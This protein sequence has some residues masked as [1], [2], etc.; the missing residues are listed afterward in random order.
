AAVDTPLASPR[1]WLEPIPHGKR[2]DPAFASYTEV[3]LPEQ[4]VITVEDGDDPSHGRLV[5]VTQ[6]ALNE[7]R[8]AE[9]KVKKLKAA[10]KTCTEK[11]HI[12]EQRLKTAFQKQRAQYHKDFARLEQE[13]QEAETL[14][15]QARVVL[16]QVA[17]GL[18]SEGTELTEEPPASALPSADQVF[19][20]WEREDDHGDD[21]ILRRALAISMRTP[22]R[23]VRA[24]PR[25][26]AGGRPAPRPMEVEP[27]NPMSTDPYTGATPMTVPRGMDD[28]PSM[29]VAKTTAAPS[30]GQVPKHPG[31]R[32]LESARVPTAVAPPRPGIKDATKDATKAKAVQQKAITERLESKRQGLRAATPFGLGQMPGEPGLGAGHAEQPPGTTRVDLANLAIEADDDEDG[33]EEIDE[34]LAFRSNDLV[35]AGGTNMDFS[36]PAGFDRPLSSQIPGFFI[37]QVLLWQLGVFRGATKTCRGAPVELVAYQ[38]A[39]A[40]LLGGQPIAQVEHILLAENEVDPTQLVQFLGLSAP[41][42]FRVSFWPRPRENGRLRLHEGDVVTFGYVEIAYEEEDETN[43]SSESSGDSGTDG[44][45]DGAEDRNIPSSA[46]G[47]NR[48]A[49]P[50]PPAP[51]RALLAEDLL[52][53]DLHLAPQITTV[54]CRVFV[55]DFIPERVEVQLDLPATLQEL[56]Q[57]LH[58]GRDPQAVVRFPHLCPVEP[59]T[60]R[61]QALFVALPEWGP[62][63]V[64]A[65][66]NTAVIDSRVFAAYLPPYATAD[67]LLRAA[68]LPFAA[69]FSVFVGDDPEPLPDGVEAH[70][71]PGV[72]ILIRH[73]G[74]EPGPQPKLPTLLGSPLHWTQVEPLP[75]PDIA[76]AYCLAQEHTHCL[77]VTDFDSSPN[78]RRYLAEAIGATEDNCRHFSATPTV[79]DCSV[80][81]VHCCSALAA[82]QTHCADLVDGLSTVLLDKRAVA[83][84]FRMAF[85]AT[86]SRAY[87]VLRSRLQAET[88]LGWEVFL[89]PSGDQV[90]DAPLQ[91]GQ[92]FAVGYRR[93]LG[94]ADNVP[95]GTSTDNQSTAANAPRHP[96]TQAASVEDPS[97]RQSGDLEGR[98]ASAEPH[99]SFGLETATDNADLIFL[100]LAPDYRPESGVITLDF[101][102]TVPLAIASVNAVRSEQRWMWFPVVIPVMPQPDLDYLYLL[103]KPS[104]PAFGVFVAFDTRAIDGRLFCNNVPMLATRQS[105]LA[106]AGQHGKPFLQVFVRDMPWPLPEDQGVDLQEGDLIS[107]CFPDDRVAILSSPSDRLLDRGKAFWQARDAVELKCGPVLSCDTPFLKDHGRESTVDLSLFSISS[108]EIFADLLGPHAHLISNWWDETRT[109]VNHHRRQSL[110]ILAG[111]V[112]S[113]VGS[114]TS[115]G[116]GDHGAETEDDPGTRWRSLIEEVGCLAPC[117]FAAFQWGPTATYQHK[118]GGGT[119][120]PDMIAIPATWASGILQA[121]VAP[122][123][124]VALA[125]PDHLATCVSVK[126]DFMPAGQTKSTRKRHFPAQLFTDPGNREHI[127][128]AFHSIPSVPWGV[129]AHAHAA[130]VVSHLQAAFG[131]IKTRSPARPR[132]PYVSE[133]TWCL[134][135][136]ASKLRRRLQNLREYKRGQLCAFCFD[137]WRRSSA[138]GLPF[139]PQWAQDWNHWFFPLA[140]REIV[141]LVQ[142]R[143]CCRDLRQAC[144]HDRDAYVC[145]LTEEVATRP[146]SEVHQAIHRLLCHRRKKPYSLEP[147]PTIIDAQ[148]QVCVDAEAVQR[149]WRQHF[150][151]IEGGRAIDP[152]AL[153]DHTLSAEQAFGPWPSPT[154]AIGLPN[155][156]DL[157]RMVRTAKAGKAP[158]M[159]GLPSELL[160]GFSQQTAETLMPLLLKLIFRGAEAVGFKGAEAV[161]F[162]K[163][164]G[165]T[166]LC[167]NFRSI[168]LIP[169]FSKALHQTL[170]PQIRDLYVRTAPDL[171]LGGK[172]QKN[173]VFG[174]HICRT[175]L[176]W[177]A[178]TSTP[179]FVLFA[180]I[181][182]AFY[183]AIR[184]LIASSTAGTSH[185]VAAG[186][187][188]NADL[189][190]SDVHAILQHMQEPTAFTAAGATQWQE[191]LADKLTESTWFLLQSDSVP[192]LTSRGTRPGSTSADLLFAMLVGRILARRD[193]LLQGLGSGPQVPLVPWDGELSLAPPADAAPKVPLDD[194]VWADDISCMRVS[195]NNSVLAS[196]VACT[197]GGLS[198]AFTEFGFRLSYGPAKTAA[199]VQAVGNGSRKARQL[200]FSNRGLKGSMLEE[201]RFRA[202]QGLDG[203]RNAVIAAYAGL[204]RVLGRGMQHACMDTVPMRIWLRIPPSAKVV[205]ATKHLQTHPQ[206]PPMPVL[207]AQPGAPYLDYV[208]GISQPLLA[209]LRAAPIFDEELL[210]EV[211]TAVIEPVQ[212]L[213]DTVQ[214]WKDTSLNNS[215]VQDAAD[216]ILLLLDP[217]LLADSV[218]PLPKPKEFPSDTVPFWPDLEPFTVPA[219]G[220]IFL[221][222][223]VSPP[224]NVLSPFGYT[225]LSLKAARAYADWQKHRKH[226]SQHQNVQDGPPERDDQLFFKPRS[227]DAH[228][229]YGDSSVTS[230]SS[231][232]SSHHQM[233][234]MR[235]QEAT[236]GVIPTYVTMASLGPCWIAQGPMVQLPSQANTPPVQP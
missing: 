182:A 52:A 132:H 8:K 225:S 121:W 111:D 42:C 214:L 166:Q 180:D 212:V 32:P 150:A 36:T 118:R 222:D 20:D 109:L 78:F 119:S 79:T 57:V 125:T 120:R 61:G 227:H 14:Q 173:V 219:A 62:F 201:L 82:C 187:L 148:G 66:F 191:S 137:V 205:V 209:D 221:A 197:A 167:E 83:D 208:P 133:D 76:R 93:F 178:S 176:R 4:S 51:I 164:K 126:V 103:A 202:A 220:E 40:G 17:T 59:Q 170:R 3:V 157:R 138:R 140:L 98:P 152:A 50:P 49:G 102:S 65:V 28:A 233:N 218:Q 114:V 106:A 171:Q 97:D 48:P 1:L 7:A 184:P 136:Q 110:V 172:P 89:A 188:L 33:L 134:Q 34:P 169:N 229:V 131:A 9:N 189:P 13:V 31:Q 10:L 194:L 144:K 101:P 26:P 74:S 37:L 199:L 174:S 38:A 71:F 96:T 47:V 155:F 168:L 226:H 141:A 67:F 44:D 223:L 70:L 139:E 204:Y 159:D 22:A 58:E 92:V 85:I 108:G 30:P 46:S 25:T 68:E 165:S 135:R 23:T 231:Q 54:V 12:Y 206:A 105:L 19:G 153:V 104:W 81:G 230:G 179:S 95:F 24:Q 224:P 177:T 27:T 151:S 84:G 215:E 60:V 64:V 127:L 192:V 163:G 145:R 87:E 56:E 193:E 115:T 130:I 156:C 39:L 211:V 5:P 43:S 11:W 35:S 210:W 6:S 112:N 55:P 183:S 113:S 158:G 146:S 94:T 123:V 162:Y 190:D 235:P 124:H 147:L 200:L 2:Q 181:S 154:T 213:R 217:D 75:H 129:S 207:E 15:H 228:V 29:D 80:A 21:G 236:Y 86:S 175:F 18:G 161:R 196:S 234:Q 116:V 149:R 117:T 122:E 232:A 73:E 90:D 185:E 160:R 107:I 142:V 128:Q 100:L 195:H 99:G 77:F 63:L 216:N 45:E 198:D 91:E 203:C 53:Q 143:A 69:G 186:H 88:P 72:L 41:P 16:C